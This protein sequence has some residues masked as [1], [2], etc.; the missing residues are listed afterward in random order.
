VQRGDDIITKNVCTVYII[1]MPMWQSIAFQIKFCICWEKWK[2][3][4]GYKY[5]HGWRNLSFSLS[6]LCLGTCKNFFNAAFCLYSSTWLQFNDFLT[7]LPLYLF[8]KHA[9]LN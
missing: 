9:A 3:E 2:F 7:P 8:S 6:Y 5:E 1:W 4:K